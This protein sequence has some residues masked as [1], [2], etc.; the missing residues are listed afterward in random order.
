M[1]KRLI[2]GIVGTVAVFASVV[3]VGYALELLKDFQNPD[4]SFW[5][6]VLG[7]FFMC[8]I[9][10]AGS[11]IGIRFLRFASSGR[12]QQSNSWV[13]PILLGVGLFFPGS[14]FSLPITILW[15][16]RTWPGDDGKTNLAF[17]VSVCIGVAVAIVGTMMLLRK[18]VRKN[19]S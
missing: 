7:E 10:L 4:V 15:V 11:W 14:V 13:K 9:A 6:N 16:S 18:R 8:S 17:E 2:A 19:A 3:S 5:L 12:S 1:A